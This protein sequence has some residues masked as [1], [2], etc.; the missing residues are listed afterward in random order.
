[1]KN[2]QDWEF[3]RSSGYAGYRNKVTSEW[4]Y[5]NEY[6]NRFRETENWLEAKA[7]ELYP[8]GC[9]GTNRSAE[10][11]RRIFIT[12]YNFAKKQ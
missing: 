7:L 9:D 11:Y 10:V 12:G 8:D 6:L 4:I 2:K 1:M 3:E 5:E